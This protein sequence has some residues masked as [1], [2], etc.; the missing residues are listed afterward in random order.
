MGDVNIVK[1]EETYP[2]NLK[3]PAD[4][5]KQPMA[6]PGK[7][8]LIQAPEK[9]EIFLSVYDKWK[10]T[11]YGVN[12]KDI[13]NPELMNMAA[14]I[15]PYLATNIEQTATIFY[16]NNSKGWI[17]INRN[18]YDNI[19]L[20]YED[21]KILKIQHF[22]EYAHI[23]AVGHFAFAITRNGF[24]FLHSSGKEQSINV[25]PLSIRSLEDQLFI[26]VV[27][28][29][30]LN[31]FVGQEISQP[32]TLRWD[33]VEDK[34][35]FYPNASADFYYHD[36]IWEVAIN[37]TQLQTSFSIYFGEPGKVMGTL[38]E[39]AQRALLIAITVPKDIVFEDKGIS[40]YVENDMVTYVYMPQP[41]PPLFLG[42]YVI[43]MPYI[44]D[45][46]KMELRRITEWTDITNGFVEAMLDNGESLTL[47][48]WHF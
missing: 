10:G 32:G 27:P 17:Y 35:Y 22:D 33:A 34:W 45:L 12:K 11:V 21:G 42:H 29:E 19:L 20:L 2:L 14:M 47:P 15:Q 5:F 39:I 4:K 16:Y 3:V 48:I 40:F 41:S 36:E 26:R 46:A 6:I 1:I 7:F 31:D 23:N 28:S 24:T 18:N 8:Y 13:F 44:L 43:Y 38:S 9:E 37:P 25:T 30:G